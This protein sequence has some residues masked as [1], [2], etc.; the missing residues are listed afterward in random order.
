MT[1]PPVARRL[2]QGEAGRLQGQERWDSAQRA[3]GP[4]ASSEG[5]DPEAGPQWASRTRLLA[6]RVWGAGS[7]PTERGPGGATKHPEAQPPPPPAW[8]HSPA[9]LAV[10]LP[11]GDG[12]EGLAAAPAARLLLV[13]PGLRGRSPGLELQGANGCRQLPAQADGQL[14]ERHKAHAG[15]KRHTCRRGRG[16]SRISH[17][18]CPACSPEAALLSRGLRL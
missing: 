8:T 5:R 14:C 15:Q 10:V 12:V 13:T 3:V 7:A 1:P 2:R 6:W 16:R 9:Q 17:G 11:L 18:P 4:G